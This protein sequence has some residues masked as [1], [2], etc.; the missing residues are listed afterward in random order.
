MD[1]VNLSAKFEVCSFTGGKNSTRSSSCILVCLN[2][3][4]LHRN[5][6]KMLN[7]GTPVNF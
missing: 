1:P 4:P 7:T 5:T 6:Q 2:G 3:G